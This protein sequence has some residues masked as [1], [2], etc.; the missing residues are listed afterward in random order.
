MTEYTDLNLGQGVKTES[1]PWREHEYAGLI[2]HHSAPDGHRCTAGIM[3]D[4][5]GVRDAFPAIP[6]W[7]VESW[8]PLTVIPAVTCETCG[9][10]GEIRDGAWMAE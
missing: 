8:T 2:Y 7:T 9:T 5:P 1:F 3:F 10:T 4:L 6:L